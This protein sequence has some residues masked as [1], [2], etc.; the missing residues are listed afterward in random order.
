MTIQQD[1]AKVVAHI[2][3]SRVTDMAEWPAPKTSP[4]SMLLVQVASGVTAPA[5]APVTCTRLELRT[6]L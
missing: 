4:P 1:V 3:Q 2:E 6:A 5:P